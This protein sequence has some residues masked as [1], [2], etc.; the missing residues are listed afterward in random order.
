MQR[1]P[2][3]CKV[4]PKEVEEF[5]GWGAD[6][7]TIFRWWNTPQIE[8]QNQTWGELWEKD[9]TKVIHLINEGKFLTLVL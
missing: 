7:D 4:V 8:L 2:E 3:N 6:A 5:I 9:P 1:D